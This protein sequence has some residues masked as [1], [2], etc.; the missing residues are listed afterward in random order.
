MIFEAAR[1]IAES[2]INSP[3][4]SRSALRRL[5]R[6]VSGIS[7][8]LAYPDSTTL[9]MVCMNCDKGIEG[10]CRLSEFAKAVISRTGYCNDAT[11]TEAP[12]S[13]DTIGFYAH[14]RR[15]DPTDIQIKPDCLK[16]F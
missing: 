14:K 10:T 7:Q 16:P 12:G 15:S 6:R 11:V 2:H 8:D 9:S 4:E 1:H 13:M 5:Q 3:R